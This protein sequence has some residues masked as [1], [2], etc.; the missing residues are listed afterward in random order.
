VNK[1]I[2]ITQE[3]TSIYPNALQNIRKYIEISDKE[4]EDLFLYWNS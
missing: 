2:Y 3:I 4:F 1:N